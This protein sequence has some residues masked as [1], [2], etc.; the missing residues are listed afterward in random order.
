[1]TWKLGYPSGLSSTASYDAGKALYD[2]FGAAVIT[3][4]TMEMCRAVGQINTVG[5]PGGS[6][7]TC[8]N[9]INYPNIANTVFGSAPT[10]FEVDEFNGGFVRL[11]SGV[12]KNN[13]YRVDDTTATTLDT[14][15][16]LV[17]AGVLPNDYFETVPGECTYEFPSGRTPIRRDFKKVY[18]SS[19]QRFP[20]YESGLSVPLGFEGDDGVVMAYLTDERD[21]DRL[22]AFLVHKL[23]YMGM[24]AMWSTGGSG[25]NS[26]GISPLVMEAGASTIKDQYL[27]SLEDFKIVKDAKRSDD[28][29]EVMIH[30]INYWRS[31]YRG[32]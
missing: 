15:T 30:F 28:F 20:F 22:Q 3:L 21:Y 10:S 6:V 4:S 18:K 19:S 31:T 13:V 14:D 32:I 11:L 12:C 9:I 5:D 23:D 16:D 7:L 8:K 2:K 25:S 26:E 17:T 29:Y 24:D 1:M 27:W